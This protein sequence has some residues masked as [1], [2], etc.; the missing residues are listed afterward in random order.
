MLRDTVLYKHE[1]QMYANVTKAHTHLFHSSE[2]VVLLGWS[3]PSKMQPKMQCDTRAMSDMRCP[4][5][6]LGTSTFAWLTDMVAEAKLLAQPTYMLSDH[7]KPS[8]IQPS[9]PFLPEPQPLNLFKLLG[10]QTFSTKDTPLT[11][12]QNALLPYHWCLQGAWGKSCF[13]IMEIRHA[14]SKWPVQ[15]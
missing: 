14:C 2:S 5:P 9:S 15:Y 4:L 6:P 7:L 13:T 12:F 1:A 10:G 8:T 11:I 3:S